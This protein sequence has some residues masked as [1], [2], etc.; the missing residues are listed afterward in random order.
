VLQNK[1]KPLGNFRSDH[2]YML[3][4]EMEAR[5][6]KQRQMQE[7]LQEQI[8]AKKRVKEEQK[9]REQEEEM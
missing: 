2:A 8:D 9:R 5:A 4:S 6:R 7:A 3:P 1:P